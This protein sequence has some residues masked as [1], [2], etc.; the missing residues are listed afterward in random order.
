MGKQSRRQRKHLSEKR[1]RAG[2][3]G[4]PI[5]PAPVGRPSA[6]SRRA[7][8]ESREAPAVAA[9]SPAS[10]LVKG[11]GWSSWSMSM[12]LVLGGI[13]LLII[14]GLYRRYTEDNARAVVGAGADVASVQSVVQPL[15]VASPAAIPSPAGAERDKPASAMSIRTGSGV[16]P[17]SA[18]SHAR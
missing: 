5:A 17:T 15:S 1:G 18:D 11:Y 16:P 4:L 12:K 2:T 9:S 14:V 8:P 6:A 13:L 10:P 3:L 7:Y